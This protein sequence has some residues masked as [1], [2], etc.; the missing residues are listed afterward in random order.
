MSF[1]EHT[2]S[3]VLLTYD[4][5]RTTLAAAQGGPNFDDEPPP[6][7]GLG[8]AGPSDVGPADPASARES[9]DR[10][11]MP[12]GTESQAVDAASPPGAAATAGSRNFGAG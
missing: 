2:N 11:H 7:I 5:E 9:E 8:Q 3:V 6:Q 10:G 12:H 4:C 1:L